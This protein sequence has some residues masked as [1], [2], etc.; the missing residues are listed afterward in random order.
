[1]AEPPSREEIDAKLEAAEARTEARLAQLAGT[2]D[3]R[4]AN[5]DSKIDRL[6]DSVIRL[7]S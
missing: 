3:V 1:M 5:L 6:L 2:I 7:S 4:F